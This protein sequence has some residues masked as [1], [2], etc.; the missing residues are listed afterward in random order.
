MQVPNGQLL[1]S[2]EIPIPQNVIASAKRQ[3]KGVDLERF[4]AMKL[5]DITY[6]SDGLK[7]K[8]FLALPPL[9]EEKLPAIQFNRGGSGSK[10]ALTL[11]G[12]FVILGMY[13]SWG[14]VAIASQYRGQGGS[15]GIE[16]W[17]AGDTNDAKNLTTLLLSLPYVDTDRI[18]LIAGS[19]GGMMAFQMLR[20]MK[21]FRAAVTFGA[22][23]MLHILSQREYIIQTFIPFLEKEV[24]IEQAL[25]E[26]S[27]VV[28]ASEMCKTTPLLV[29]HGTGDRKVH[30]SHALELS[31]VLLDTLHPHKLILFENADHVLAGRRAE[32]NIEIR[33]WID[34]Y[35]K[36]KSKLPIVGPHGN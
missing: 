36:D 30:P 12:V 7:I 19:R 33:N 20:W 17:G 2:V 14:Y 31:K 18:G 16:E 10:G 21:V 1:S 4:L 32:S 34:R 8:G 24:S 28:W 35:V 29:L 23:T 3:Y 13:V 5:Y 27:A 15:E 9:Y 22:P 26:R 11:E 6:S 25:E